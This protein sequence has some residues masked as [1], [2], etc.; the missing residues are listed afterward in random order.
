MPAILSPNP[1]K[2]SIFIDKYGNKHEGSYF[3]NAE[4]FRGNDLGGTTNTNRVA[5]TTG[6]VK[7]EEKE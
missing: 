3:Q 2:V 5:E 4:K 7:K 1:K 6:D